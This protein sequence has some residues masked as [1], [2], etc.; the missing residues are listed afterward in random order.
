MIKSMTGFGKA[1]EDSPYGRIIIEIKTLNHKSLSINCTPFDG[2]FLLEEKLKNILQEKLFRGKVFVKISIEN[3]SESKVLQKIGINEAVAKEYLKKIKK[4]KKELGLPGEI[5]I[6]EI[7]ALPGV[8]EYGSDKKVEKLWPYIKKAADKALTKL[9]EFRKNEGRRLEKD[10]MDRLKMMQKAIKEIKKYEKQSVADYRK[11]LSKTIDELIGK[12][13]ADKSRVEQEVA[14]FA[15]NCD[16]TEE[17]VR[18]EHHCQSYKSTIEKAKTDVGKKLD[19]IA[20]EMHRETN[21][22]GAKASDFRISKA[23]IDIKSEIEKTREQ[24]KNIE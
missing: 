16:I 19:F 2:F 11:K 24:L 5:E 23:V 22:I 6:K 9:I 4:T 14:I 20:Q 7:I 10:F 21:T 15:K 3:S 18:L 8:I 1:A 17:V 12:G 13:E